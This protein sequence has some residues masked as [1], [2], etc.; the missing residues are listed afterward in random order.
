M[1]DPLSYM[2]EELRRSLYDDTVEGLARRLQRANPSLA[3]Q[4]AGLRGILRSGGIQRKDV[5]DELLGPPLKGPVADRGMGRTAV[6]ASR[7]WP[8]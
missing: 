1:I 5:F 6:D 7:R 8:E 4:H 3:A 2:P